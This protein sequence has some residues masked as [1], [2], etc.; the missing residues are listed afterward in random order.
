MNDIHGLQC[1]YASLPAQAI[2]CSL[3]GVSPIGAQWTKNPEINKHFN[4]SFKAT[5]KASDNADVPYT[6]HLSS[7]GYPMVDV[8]DVLISNHLANAEQ[9]P[10]MEGKKV[11]VSFV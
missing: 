3:Q 2:P 11:N 6:V 9:A 7:N 4:G 1:R 10:V 8:A 5:F